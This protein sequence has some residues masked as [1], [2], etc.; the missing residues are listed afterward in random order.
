[1][2][3]RT[4]ITKCRTDQRDTMAEF[5]LTPYEALSVAQELIA[6]AQDALRNS[7]E[8][9]SVVLPAKVEGEDD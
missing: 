7:E 6:A 1:M 8:S 3:P 5:V 4:V 2:K 9:V